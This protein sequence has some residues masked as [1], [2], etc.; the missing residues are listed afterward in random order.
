M[1]EN[2][3]NLKKQIDI[4]VQK[5]W[6]IPKTMN[7]NRNTSRHTIIKMAK[8]KGITLKIATEKQSH[9]REPP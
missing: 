7:P 6:R 2:F 1:S 4:Q 5:P 9:T 3:L 8:V